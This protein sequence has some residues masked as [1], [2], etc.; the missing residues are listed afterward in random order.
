MEDLV[1]FQK[2]ALDKFIISSSKKSISKNT[3]DKN[4]ASEPIYCI[5][6]NEDEI[7]KE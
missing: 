7:H 2:G 6:P 5:V 3:N 4:L 1:Q